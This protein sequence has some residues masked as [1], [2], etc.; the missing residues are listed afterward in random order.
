[1]GNPV[2]QPPPCFEIGPPSHE[3]IEYNDRTQS[4]EVKTPM[5]SIS[6]VIPIRDGLLYE[7]AYI[8]TVKF[9]YPCDAY[10]GIQYGKVSIT[11][12]NHHERKRL[13]Q[14]LAE[15]AVKEK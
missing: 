7:V 4:L 6:A 1:M 10:H 15:L 8:R 2:L 9:E 5:G 12:A 13:E 14:L 3:T 11:L